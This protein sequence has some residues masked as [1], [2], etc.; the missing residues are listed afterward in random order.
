MSK[1]EKKFLGHT[2]DQKI[3]EFEAMMQG[4]QMKE[5][6]GLEFDLW[7]VLTFIFFL[8]FIL[9]LYAI[10]GKEAG[11]GWRVYFFETSSGMPPEE[12]LWLFISLTGA[13][14]S[15]YKRIRRLRSKK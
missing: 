7:L 10:I 6:V 12:V 13:A 14:I 1:P 2:E 9:A 5:R 3:R 4:E 15:I 11:L 8:G